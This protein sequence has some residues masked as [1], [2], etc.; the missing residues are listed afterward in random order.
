[1]KYTTVMLALSLSTPVQAEIWDYSFNAWVSG[2]YSVAGTGQI[3]SDARIPGLPAFVVAQSTRLTAW[4]EIGTHS[5]EYC[6]GHPALCREAIPGVD[7]PWRGLSRDITITGAKWWDDGGL[8]FETSHQDWSPEYFVAPT[9]TLTLGMATPGPLATAPLP[10]L[11][12]SWLGLWGYR[13]RRA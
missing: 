8:R 13:R 3:V 1:M 5:G 10:A 9:Y 12:L 11:A 2:D 6:S 4:I 7:S